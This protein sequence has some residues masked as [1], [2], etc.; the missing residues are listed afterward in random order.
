MLH[1]GGGCD[2]LGGYVADREVGRGGSARVYRAHRAADPRHVVALKVLDEDHRTAVQQARLKR[3][4]EFARMLDHPH[5]VT[6]YE[7]DSFWL[8][9]QFVDGGNCTALAALDD[10]LTVLAQ[11]AAALDFA[12]RSGIVHCDV[13]PANILVG[14]NFAQLGAVLTDFGVAHAVVEDV[15][16]RQHRLPVSL[17]YAAPELL[18]GHPPTAA[19]DQY[20]LACTAVELLTGTPPFTADNA[21]D[22]VNAQLH[23]RPPPIAAGIRVS[24]A[25]DTALGRAMAKSPELRYPS[26]AEF[27]AQLDRTLSRR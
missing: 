13:K 24:R 15:G 1:L 14:A 5:I 21:A 18:R 7:R 25:L 17:P 12:H 3:E 23:R 2:A 11:I 20:A 8:T 9:M 10:R 6:M 26:C 16:R 4:F 22:L 19:T 27:V